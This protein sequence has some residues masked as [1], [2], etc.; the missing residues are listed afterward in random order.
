MSDLLSQLNPSQKEA[1]THDSGPL[2]I[3]AGAGTGKT[4]VLIN[5]LAYL[6]LEKKTKIDE[7]LIMT[8]TEKATAEMEERADK[9]LPYG[10]FD[11]WLNTFHG[12]CERVLRQDGL[13]I[14]LS[15]DFKL[16]SATEQWMLIKNHLD[17]LNLDYYRPLGNPTKF[18][19]ELVRHFSRLKDEN[20]S[21]TDYLDYAVGLKQDEDSMLSGADEEGFETGR[22]NELAQAYQT[23]NQLLLDNKFLDFGDL[24][25]YTL[26]LFKERPNILAKYRNQFKY[27]MVDEFQDT[28]WAQYELVK[29]LAQPN[30]NL[31]VVGD[32]NQSIYKFRG[33]SLSNIMQFKDDYPQAKEIILND[34]YRSGQQILDLAYH[35]IKHNDPNTLEAKLGISKKLIG[36]QTE[37]GEVLYHNFPSELEEA[38]FVVS[39]I[40]KLKSTQPEVN[41]TDFAILVRANDTADKYLQE[42]KRRD[43]PHQFVSLRGLYYKPIILDL[44]AYFKLL[45]NYHESS[46]LY[47]V[48]N[49]NIFAV[50][51][52][53][54]VKIHQTARTKV[55]SLYET[56][57]NINIITDIA[58]ESVKAINR[59]LALI[60]KHSVLVKTEKPSKIMLS[61]LYDSELLK[62]LDHDINR[63]EF[64]YLN[65]F[66]QKLKNFETDEPDVR[67]KDF[68]VA[69]ELEREAGD[70]GSLRLPPDDFDTI[71]VMTIH[72]AKGLEFK[73]VFLV[74]LV[75]KKFP[76]ISRGEKISIPLE[77][78]KEKN[79]P[80]KDT[81]L[82]EE[83]RLFYVAVTRAKKRLYLL[84]AKDYGGAREKK[85]SRFIME[86]GIDPEVDVTP[87]VENELLLEL[88]RLNN[89]TTTKSDQPY[90][91]PERFSFSQLAA[92]ETC[93]WQYKLA[94]VLGIPA[95][96]DKP[97]LIFGKVMHEVLREF[98]TPLLPG[99][100]V[101]MDLFGNQTGP[102]LSNAKLLSLYDKCW[103]PDGYRDVSERQKYYER[104]RKS[105]ELFSEHLVKN[106]QPKILF[107]EKDFNFKLQDETIKG[108]ID[109]VDELAD[110]SLAIVDYKTGN[111][112]EKLEWT[113]KKQLILYQL[114][115][116]E[117]LARPVSQLT[118]YYL[119]NG[120]QA[121][122]TTK[123]EE[124]DKLRLEIAERMKAIRSLDFVPTPSEHAC[125]FCD[126]NG[127][128]EFRKT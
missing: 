79:L 35:F 31:V 21:S 14:G 99:S 126:F 2:L 28:N 69:L 77:L 82:E 115:L 127:I 121:S 118:Y 10:Y 32:D 83:R 33:A 81:H 43:L 23:Y 110:G 15:P 25:V 52:L 104:G 49:M 128:C 4:T 125:N 90:A 102:D 51:H 74:D 91:L 114:F 67:L 80:D 59:L 57:K 16:L 1:V 61:F 34:N 84:A 17:D 105:L 64:S 22:I 53:D 11:L 6:V 12:F 39:E 108:K 60:E 119:E 93:P 45:D 54:L 87:K 70:T 36:H 117:A 109:R 122:F 88:E 44:I 98:L 30:N 27:V 19:H 85:P 50:N 42:L 65:Q 46:A 92:Y 120:H 71:K 113:D 124:K 58:P 47:R 89:L 76:T 8:F 78:A 3:V 75:D 48:L 20:V 26:K 38:A 73:Y 112:K 5:R 40:E 41:W 72:A 29:L 13:D 37:L 18:I 116:E 107:I 100:S 24:I 103:Q 63:E 62:T 7:V 86:S 9:I 94:F 55:W 66:F 96:Q 97:S 123:P 68:V 111:P 106:G 101:K 95:P 56:L